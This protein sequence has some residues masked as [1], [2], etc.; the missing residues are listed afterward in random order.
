MPLRALA[1]TL[2]LGWLALAAG[3][4]PDSAGA[5]GIATDTP[6][7]KVVTPRGAA[8]TL[9]EVGKFE[10]RPVD[11]TIPGTTDIEADLRVDVYPKVGP[12][13]IKEVLVDE[14]SEVKVGQPLLLLNDVDFKIEVARRDAM[15]RQR[16]QSEK[17]A[18]S[19][20]KEAAARA[21]AQKAQFDKAKADFQRA[22]DTQKGGIE[23]LTEKEIQDTEA[24]FARQTAEL[25]ALDLGVERSKIEVELA[26]LATESAKIELDA[27]KKDLAD[28]IVLSTIDGVVQRRDV[29]S[30]LLVNS[31][32]HLFTLVDPSRLRA[33][34]SIN[35]DQFEAVSHLGLETRLTLGA[36][37]KDTF[38]GKI[39]AINPS[40]DPSSGQIRVRVRLPDNA[41]GKV[42]PGMFAKAAILVGS[43]EGVVVNK[44]AIVR[45]DKKDWLFS[46]ENGVAR[47][48]L[49]ERDEASHGQYEILTV[50]G[51]PPDMNMRVILVGQ[52]RLRD[53]DP[54]SIATGSQ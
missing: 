9:V 23:V 27:A 16:Q 15:W 37:P 35:Q 2:G 50:D 33:Y 53:G 18:D 8:T 40:V 26:K 43:K 14:G 31:S 36:F 46:F 11:S 32:T 24:E 10:L 20:S 19:Q 17:Q 6:D 28:T 44:R 7:P 21:R 51:A 29:N 45:E 22:L 48:H 54:V 52:D 49:V 41:I 38:I 30:G 13:Y 34:V 39:E 42:K 1:V 47:R 12:A 3:C 25:E 5:P 4:S